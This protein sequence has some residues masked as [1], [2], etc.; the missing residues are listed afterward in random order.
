MKDE[1]LAVIKPLSKYRPGLIGMGVNTPQ[2]GPPWRWTTSEPN[3]NI[4]DPGYAGIVHD[5][6][7]PNFPSLD[8]MVWEGE[9]RE[10]MKEAEAD[11]E[12]KAK[13]FE[14]KWEEAVALGIDAPGNAVKE[15]FN[16]NQKGK[17]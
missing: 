6:E 17:E 1:R 7:Y 5:S 2:P 16:L 8:S 15:F 9:P 3:L 14:K 13:E 12:A 11:G 4:G 10:T